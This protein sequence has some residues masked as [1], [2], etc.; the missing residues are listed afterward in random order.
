MGSLWNDIRF[1]LRMLRKNFGF[2]VTA[3]L[4]LALG[5]GVNTAMFSLAANLLLRPL[6]V[7]KPSELVAIATAT[8]A[9]TPGLSWKMYE[10]YRDNSSASFTG[11][12]GYSENIPMQ[13]SRADGSTLTAGGAVVTGNY[14]DVLGVRA[15][16]GRLITAQDDSGANDPNVAVISH[17]AWREL[18]G[19]RSDALGSTLR[20]FCSPYYTVVGTRLLQISH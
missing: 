19:G 4:I 3:V 6:S 14:F 18:F 2:T 17:R 1:G 15:F 20:S 13:I 12:A 7:T 11:L 5:I 8:N 9:R 10:E 16:R